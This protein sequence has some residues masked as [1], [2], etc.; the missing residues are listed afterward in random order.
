V[1]YEDF[2]NVFIRATAAKG[3]CAGLP[4]PPIGQKAG[5]VPFFAVSELLRLQRLLNTDFLGRE[6]S[7]FDGHAQSTEYKK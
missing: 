4:A 2:P 7:A 3:Y 6:K 5:R 1:Y